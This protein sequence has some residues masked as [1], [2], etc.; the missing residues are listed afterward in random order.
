[1]VVVSGEEQ[2]A[3][4]ESGLPHYAKIIA[5]VQPSI[6]A[7]FIWGVSSSISSD[8]ASSAAILRACMKTC[9]K[10]LTSCKL[11]F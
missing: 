3:E 6:F 4:V 5:L 9:S 8:D 2:P 11:P 10:C 7:C 1:M